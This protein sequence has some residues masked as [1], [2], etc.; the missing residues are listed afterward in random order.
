MLEMPHREGEEEVIMMS[1]SMFHFDALT[2]RTARLWRCRPGNASPLMRRPDRVLAA[3][4]IFAALLILASVPLAGAVGTVAYSD[5]AAE[6]RAERAGVSVVHARVL[7]RP[8]PTPAHR[9]RA[10]VTWPGESGPVV[11]TVTVARH[12]AEGDVIPVWLNDSGEPVRAP[13]T[14]AAAVVN[15]IGTA[16]VILISAGLAA[17]GM[18]YA[19]G[20][21]VAR[22]QSVDWGRYLLE[23]NR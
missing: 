1:A 3:V 10:K 7:D 21:L 17:V 4:R 5:D 23:L 6:I 20:L 15:G 13:R 2:P 9:Y 19:V 14:P 12:T 8:E 16:V 18:T 11:A 22:R